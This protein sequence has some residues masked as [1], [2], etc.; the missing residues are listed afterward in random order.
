M[1]R[2]ERTRRNASR[3]HLGD[4]LRE[5]S[6]VCDDGAV[7]SA[8]PQ[9]CLVIG[10]EEL[11]ATR[12]V[13]EVTAAVR[14]LDDEADVR[15]LQAGALVP[16]ELAELL[17]PSLFGGRRVLV[18]RSGQDAKKDLVSALIGVEEAGDRLSQEELLAMVVNLIG[19]AVG[20]SDAGI[21]N[22]VHLMTTDP[23]EVAKVGN[24]P[25]LIEPFVEEVLRFRPPFRSSRRKAVHELEIAGEHLA[26]GE[27]VYISRQAANRD[28]QRFADPDIFRVERRGERHL[29]FGYGP[30][31]CLGQA[32][33]RLNLNVAATVLTR[34]WDAV[35]V[36]EEPRRV[37][38]DPAERFEALRVRAHLR[39]AG[40]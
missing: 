25:T 32:L 8:P 15:D 36:L 26:A 30:H 28:P 19:G 13:A 7:T 37:P 29:S 16:G 1:V 5:R 20:S 9:V 14:A 40:R 2:P 27:T 34:H 22:M 11:L 6:D 4:R 35:E 39:G 21:V 24:D 38:F 31:Y 23:D 18:L 33:A 10:D 3:A 12:A 17:S